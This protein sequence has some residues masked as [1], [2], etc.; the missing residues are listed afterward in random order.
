MRDGHISFSMG[1][2]F[3]WALIQ[4]QRFKYFAGSLNTA[5]LHWELCQYIF[6]FKLTRCQ[7]MQLTLF[8]PKKEKKDILKNSHWADAIHVQ[9]VLTPEGSLS[10]RNLTKKTDRRVGALGDVSWSLPPLYASQNILIKQTGREKYGKEK[11]KEEK[12]GLRGTIGGWRRRWGAE[13]EWQ[14]TKKMLTYGEKL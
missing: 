7:Q 6:R 8:T 12:I 10:V 9:W 14:R 1:K 3:N 11:Q 13:S 4:Y 5:F 2:Q